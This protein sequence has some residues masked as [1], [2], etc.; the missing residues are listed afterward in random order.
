MDKAKGKTILNNIDNK[1]VANNP[2]EA[3]KSKIK[4]V[5][6]DTFFSKADKMGKSIEIYRWT[7]KWWTKK[8]WF[9]AYTDNESIA[10]TYWEN[11]EKKVITPKKIADFSNPTDD[12][13]Q[14]IKDSWEWWKYY[15]ID[16]L[17]KLATKEK[18]WWMDF[19][20]IFDD[21]NVIKALSDK[22]YDVVKFN[23]FASSKWNFAKHTT[24]IELNKKSPKVSKDLQ[25]LYDEAR[26]K[27]KTWK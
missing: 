27:K 23:D 2:T 12:V 15:D 4:S 20:E 1:K 13:L 21:K 6:S 24:Y 10:K 14:I 19:Y 8:F 7:N 5:Q 9:D 18:M 17:R 26:K 3:L 11:I 25:P 16:R 22:W